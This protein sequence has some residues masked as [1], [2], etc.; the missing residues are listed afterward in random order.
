LAPF[1]GS[2][3]AYY[4]ALDCCPATGFGMMRKDHRNF[5]WVEEGRALV[6]RLPGMCPYIPLA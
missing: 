4:I 3:T 6:V 1:W 5:S 2:G